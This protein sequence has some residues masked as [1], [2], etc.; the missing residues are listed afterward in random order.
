MT[1][2]GLGVA[3]L[4][5]NA[6]THF[7]FTNALGLISAEQARRLAAAT[8]IF[9][10][11]MDDR[12]AP[13]CDGVS[14]AGVDILGAGGNRAHQWQLVRPQA[15]SFRGPRHRNAW[16][17]SYRLDRRVRRL[18]IVSA[19]SPIMGV[20]D[21]FHALLHSHIGGR[22]RRAA[23]APV[24]TTSGHCR[25][26]K[27]DLESAG[28]IL[29]RLT[30]A[31]VVSAPP[32]A[33]RAPRRFCR[34]AAKRPS[35]LRAERK[36]FVPSLQAEMLPAHVIVGVQCLDRSREAHMTLLEDV[37]A[38]AELD[39]ELGVLLASRIVSPCSFRWPICRPRSRTISGAKPSEGSSSSSSSGLPIKVRPIVSI[40]CS[41]PRQIAALRPARPA[42]PGTART[43]PRRSS[44]LACADA[45]GCADVEVLRTVRSGKM[46]RS[47]GTKPMPGW[48]PGS[49]GRPVMSRR[50]HRTVPRRRRQPHDRAHAS[51]SCRRRCGREGHALALLDSATRRTALADKP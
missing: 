7:S 10:G 1:E 38:V 33:S 44:C 18:K 6:E 5:S 28:E 45:A 4:N 32:P 30:R 11:P 49:G 9:Q 26:P 17:S 27:P 46:R 14:H 51:S 19:P 2:D 50:C 16:P 34:E 25:D 8:A 39:C 12:P 41:P 20:G 22:L 48:R 15:R 40:C 3:V 42:A 29:D 31:F 13:P 37:G 21:T 23:A 43:P 36:D 35:A 24:A 47:S